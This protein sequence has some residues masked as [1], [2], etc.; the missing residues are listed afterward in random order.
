MGRNGEAIHGTRPWRVFGEGPAKVGDGMM[1]EGSS[2]GFSAEDIRFT[3]KDG[4][5]YATAMGWPKDGLLR[6][7]TLAQDSALAPG[8]IERVEALG[9]T[10]PLTFTRTRKGLEVR[11]PEGLAGPIAVALKIRGKGLV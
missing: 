10:D 6:I 5:V 2:Q 9:S 1:S 3:T 11:L 4:A 8:V 7:T